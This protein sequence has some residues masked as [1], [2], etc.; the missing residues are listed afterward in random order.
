[1]QIT[2]PT[3]TSTY[4]QPDPITGSAKDL[5]AVALAVL[6]PAAKYLERLAISPATT[7]ALITEGAI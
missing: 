1:M 6:I 2:F 4:P 3:G 5:K 7:A